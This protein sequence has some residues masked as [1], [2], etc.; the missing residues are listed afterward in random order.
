MAIRGGY[1]ISYLNIGNNN[2]GLIMN[3]PYN[4]TVSLQNVRSTI[5]AAERRAPLAP[6]ALSA[7]DPNFKRPMIQSWSL[8][9]QREICR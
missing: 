9:V 4:H 5:P 3:P 6:S 8:T 1:G 2:S 7:Y